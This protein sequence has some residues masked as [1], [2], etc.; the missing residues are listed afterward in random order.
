PLS[1]FGLSRVFGEP[2]NVKVI[3]H[4]ISL[5][6]LLLSRIGFGTPRPARRILK[7]VVSKNVV[8]EEVKRI[9]IAYRKSEMI[10]AERQ[11]AGAEVDLVD[12][13]ECPLD[14]REEGVHSRYG[15]RRAQLQR[16]LQM[17]FRRR[18]HERRRTAGN[19]EHPRREVEHRGFGILLQTR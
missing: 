18:I 3:V 12:H 19:S 11:A 7:I 14:S 5:F 1:D 4:T 15:R 9:E 6:L 10:A 17:V 16:L 13:R 2:Q 8:V